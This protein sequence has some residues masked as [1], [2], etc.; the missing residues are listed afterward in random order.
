[1]ILCSCLSPFWSTLPFI[2]CSLSL[3]S[4][5]YHVPFLSLSL[6][7]SFCQLLFGFVSVFFL[8]LLARANKHYGLPLINQATTP[9]IPSSFISRFRYTEG[10]I[11][12]YHFKVCIER[13]LASSVI[14]SLMSPCYH[15]PFLSFSLLLSCCHIFCLL[16]LFLVF[17]ICT[18]EQPMYP[19]RPGVMRASRFNKWMHGCMDGWMDEWRNHHNPKNTKRN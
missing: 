14:R 5:C 13:P 10:F 2:W 19:S 11:P 6:L 17:F 1:M 4:P 15:V 12:Y 9:H 3:L 8:F 18:C 7:L 16:C